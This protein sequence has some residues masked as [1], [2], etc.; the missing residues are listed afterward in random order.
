MLPCRRCAPVVLLVG[1]LALVGCTKGPQLAPVEGTVKLK[2]KALDRIQVEF[3]PEGNGPRS[4]GE[5]D[6]QG[7]YTLMTDDGKRQGAVVGPH[8]VVLRDAGV[9]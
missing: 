8:K 7:R 2:G 3:W 5:T 9:L 4:I 1:L 6:S